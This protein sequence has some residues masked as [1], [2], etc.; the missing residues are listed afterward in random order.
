MEILRGLVILLFIIGLNPISA[1]NDST[2]TKY[3]KSVDH[4]V[5]IKTNPVSMLSGRVF[6]TSEFR[7]T[8]EIISNPNNSSEVSFSYITFSPLFR[9]IF[10]QGGATSINGI[11]YNQPSLTGFRVQITEKFY[12]NSKDR[13]APFGWYIGPHLSYLSTHLSASNSIGAQSYQDLRIV[14][15]NG[16]LGFQ[17]L[18]RELYF[19]DMFILTG[20][21]DIVRTDYHSNGSQSTIHRILDDTRPSGFQFLP[22]FNVGISF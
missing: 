10:A 13:K 7:G 22:G 20:Y 4:S 9:D 6:Y 1:Q 2:K 15:V 12:I 5:I 18:Y 19:V 21:R 3:Q 14:S 8:L 11:N 17:A 16:R